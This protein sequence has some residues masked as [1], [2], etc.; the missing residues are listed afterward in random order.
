MTAYHSLSLT[1]TKWRK[2]QTLPNLRTGTQGQ[3]H[4]AM[5][6]YTWP[7][8]DKYSY[9]QS[10]ASMHCLMQP[11]RGMYKHGDTCPAL[12][13][14][15]RFPYPQPRPQ[16]RATPSHSCSGCPQAAT[17][18]QPPRRTS[19]AVSTQACRF[20]QTP[21]QAAS[22]PGACQLGL[23]DCGCEDAPPEPNCHGQGSGA[24]SYFSA[25]EGRT[26]QL[27][28]IAESPRGSF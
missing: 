21:P 7:H 18:P 10:H 4:I 12:L 9:T 20:R 24:L 13:G 14:T 27:P 23:G 15:L 3:V 16:D 8:T 17:T 6:R 1:V 2:R 22:V 28:S 19:S 11:H 5:H 26:E 25:W